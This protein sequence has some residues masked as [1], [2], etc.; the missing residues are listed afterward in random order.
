MEKKVT[1]ELSSADIALICDALHFKCDSLRHEARVEF[2]KV[3]PDWDVV[4]DCVDGA[5][6][7]S[8]VL[9]KFPK[10]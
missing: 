4:V 8:H 7:F 6:A 5:S 1:L 9:G 3:F 2:D 10:E